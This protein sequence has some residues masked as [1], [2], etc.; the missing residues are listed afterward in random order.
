MKFSIIRE[1]VI[2]SARRSG[3][4]TNQDHL[5]KIGDALPSVRVQ[6]M[7][8]GMWNWIWD[9]GCGYGMW[10]WPQKEEFYI[11]IGWPRN[12]NENNQFH[13]FSHFHSFLRIWERLTKMNDSRPFNAG[14]TQDLI[15]LF[16]FP[17]VCNFA[18]LFP[19]T[20]KML[21]KMLSRS[22]LELHPIPIQYTK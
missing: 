5:D 10:N 17:M 18:T 19:L 1:T 6:E 22:T 14:N 16:W 2:L 13:Q 4:G 15:F 9:L 11:P 20:E 3:G 7:Q 12:P 8:L 21:T